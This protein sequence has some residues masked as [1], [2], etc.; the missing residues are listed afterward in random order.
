VAA[1]VAFARQPP[2]A[3]QHQHD[4][5]VPLDDVLCQRLQHCT[6]CGRHQSYMYIN[7]WEGERLAVAFML[8][9][10]CNVPGYHEAIERFMRERYHGKE[11]YGQTKP[12]KT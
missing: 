5:L 6:L 4:G 8:C 3:R 11:R 2:D 12:D 7:V 9:S 10:T 1:V